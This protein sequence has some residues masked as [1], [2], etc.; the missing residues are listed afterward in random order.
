VG[1]IG[2]LQ[3][4]V[5]RRDAAFMAKYRPKLLHLLVMTNSLV[6]ADQNQII[7]F[8][9]EVRGEFPSGKSWSLPQA[10]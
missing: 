10:K 2:E 1:F 5:Q 7:T 3:R 8:D 9:H 6:N 4:C